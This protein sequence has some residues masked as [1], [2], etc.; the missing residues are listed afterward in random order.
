MGRSW[1]GR[2]TLRPRWRCTHERM[3]LGAAYDP[4]TYRLVPAEPSLT[5]EQLA[6]AAD[7]LGGHGWRSAAGLVWNREEFLD[8]QWVADWAADYE[9]GERYCWSILERYGD[10]IPADL[11][12]LEAVSA[13]FQ[14]I[15]TF[16]HE[17]SF[18][19]ECH[20]HSFAEIDDLHLALLALYRDGWIVPLAD[21]TVVSPRLVLAPS[22]F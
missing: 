8:L 22:L 15:E 13:D 4:D 10:F 20:V 16:G 6:A 5:L 17:A 11:A 1:T 21:G 7:P 18:V 19:H 3:P 14:G 2:Q 12:V 9:A